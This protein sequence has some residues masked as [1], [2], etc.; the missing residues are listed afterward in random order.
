MVKSEEKY[1]SIM[2]IK[3]YKNKV[4][5]T[6]TFKVYRT[7]KPILI[8]KTFSSK[9]ACLS[10]IEQA[11]AGL[12]SNNM[13]NIRSKEGG[14][15]F[16]FSSGTVESCVFKTLDQAS[17]GLAFLKETIGKTQEF[18]VAFDT[19]KEQAIS[20]KKIGRAEGYDFKQVSK[21]KQAG[22]ELLDK[23]SANFYFH[24]NDAEGKPILFSRSY[25][26]KTAR[27][28][29]A[30]KLI[31]SI[32][33]DTLVTK[34]MAAGNSSVF[35]L[36]TKDEV[37][38]ARSKRFKTKTAAI[39]S[40]KAF[41]KAALGKVKILK[42]A[43]KK[44]KKKTLPKE[45]F[46]LK[47]VA[48]IGD[49][50]FEAFRSKK[51]KCHYFHFFDKK[52]KALLYS[53]AYESRSKRDAAMMESI[54]LSEDKR[55]YAIS[56]KKGNYHF[57]LQSAKGKG[58]AKSRIFSTKEELIE[59]MRYFHANAKS[60]ADVSNVLMVP[61]S[62]QIPINI[63][64]KKEKNP[65]SSSK[66]KVTSARSATPAAAKEVSPIKTES[67]KPI[68]PRSKKETPK[69]TPPKQQQQQQQPQQQQQ[70]INRRKKTPP[71]PPVP[72]P[73]TK[74]DQKQ[75]S[76]KPSNN[77]QPNNQKTPPKAKSPRT[78]PTNRTNNRTSN[79]RTRNHPPLKEGQSPKRSS[80]RT[81]YVDPVVSTKSK[82]N[83][84][85]PPR[86]LPRGETEI[87]QLGFWKW[88]IPLLLAAIVGLWLL[89]S[90]GATKEVVS[91]KPVIEKAVEPVVEK[92]PTLLG[93]NASD[94]GFKEGM[95]AAKIADF[96]SLPG[97]VFPATF[98]LDKVHFPTNQ[99]Q[100]D[101]EAYA[102]LDRMVLILKAY[103]NAVV[104][105]KGHTDNVGGTERNLV[106]SQDRASMV[107]NYLL[108]KGLNAS[109]ISA[110]GFGEIEPIETN[111]TEAG[112]SAN[113][114]SEIVLI[115]R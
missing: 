12:R 29:A 94:L 37:E 58:L 25:D 7:K 27:T 108:G 57:I 55:L 51:N 75:S 107:L 30:K 96:L 32:K 90:C 102:Q 78:E 8:G 50:G 91:A 35:L 14:G 86:I 41:K 71:T 26:G 99:D 66:K 52:G 111:D 16:L 89:R 28:K 17:D 81:N 21:T 110:K 2:N 109:R 54:K 60:Y 65:S 53:R 85:D 69:K 38:I 15:G 70:N 4:D 43:K 82:T 45:K 11:L 68:D 112:R 73:N 67:K 115:K 56:E 48:P 104:Q 20:K 101:Q 77:K 79:K 22:F 95:V 100:L 1:I 88:L 106:L 19:V 36:K 39:E 3:M 93:V 62:E 84:E 33:E 80:T 64:K 6:F 92:L 59:G 46:N 18:V 5:N 103:P 9:E 44:K 13:I 47:Q 23:D 76:P 40:L 87:P 49:I 83:K 42:L 34:I 113:R 63:N 114:R 31:T 61:S 72:T 74:Q 97:S 24:F 98:V 105:I 10:G